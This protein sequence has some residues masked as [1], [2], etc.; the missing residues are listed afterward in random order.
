MRIQKTQ[1]QMAKQRRVSTRMHTTPRPGMM[2]QKTQTQMIEAA[3]SRAQE[4]ALLRSPG[5]MILEDSDSD[6]EAVES[7]YRNAHYSKSRDDSEDS[8]SEAVESQ[9]RNANF[10]DSRDEDSEN[11]D[12]HDEAVGE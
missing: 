7:Q 6:D 4:C 8:D 2:I 11:L 1:T 5:M 10:S 3:E 9:H 12:S